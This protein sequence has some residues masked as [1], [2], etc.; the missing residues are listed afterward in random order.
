MKCKVTKLVKIERKNLL[1]C[2][3]L[4]AIGIRDELDML[5]DEVWNNFPFQTKFEKM[6]FP[7]TIAQ[8]RDLEEGIKTDEVGN[9]IGDGIFIRLMSY[10]WVTPSLYYKANPK[11]VTGVDETVE[12]TKYGIKEENGE[13]LLVWKIRYIPKIYSYIDMT[14]F[15]TEDGKCAENGGDVDGICKRV[16]DNAVVSG[17]FLLQTSSVDIREVIEFEEEL[18]RNVN[19]VDDIKWDDCYDYDYYNDGLDMDQQDE[20]F[21][22]F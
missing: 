13:R 6:L 9:V 11:S 1:P 20:R 5:I 7:P 15:E 19:D 17:R 18:E 2:F 14:L 16:F 22:N 3:M 21:W 10:R 4:K 8:V 12:K